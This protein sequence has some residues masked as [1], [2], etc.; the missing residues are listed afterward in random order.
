MAFRPLRLVNTAKVAL[1]RG[2]LAFATRNA[3]VPGS[4][5]LHTSYH[6]RNGSTLATK[7]PEDPGKTA[8]GTGRGASLEN[9]QSHR[10]QPKITDE[11]VP[12]HQPKLTPE[13]QAKT[14]EHNRDFEAHHAKANPQEDDRVDKGFWSRH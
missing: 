10:P 2:Q 5:W 9:S 12:G 8:G 6:S 4:S 3:Q 14:D 11:S 7:K 13:E 1:P